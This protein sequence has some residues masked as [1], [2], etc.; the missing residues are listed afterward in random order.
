MLT[1]VNNS[2]SNVDPESLVCPD[3]NWRYYTNY[4]VM[5]IPCYHAYVKYVSLFT[6]TS[7]CKQSGGNFEI[8]FKM[9]AIIIFAWLMMM[10]SVLIYKDSSITEVSGSNEVMVINEVA[11]DILG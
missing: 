5:C 8:F 2:H 1:S 6:D 4:T 10:L 11:I 7:G 9:A 3:N